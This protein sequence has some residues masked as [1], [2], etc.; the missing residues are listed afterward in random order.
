MKTPYS[1]QPF[2]LL[3]KEEK[4]LIHETSMRILSEIGVKVKNKRA[5]EHLTRAGCNVNKDRV[6]IPESTVRKTLDLTAK[7]VH[8]PAMDE[9]HSFTVES[10]SSTITYGTGGQALY[11]VSRKDGKF[12]RKSADGEDLENILHL[13][14]RLPNVDFVTRPVEPQVD[15]ED[16][17][18]EKMKIF[19][20]N[21]TK[22]INLANL[23]KPEK[24]DDIIEI[25]G[26]KDLLSFIVCLVVSPLS[27]D[28]GAADKLEAIAGHDMAVCI[29][30]CPQGGATAPL[31]ELGE[32]AQVNAEVLTGFVLANAV[33]PG[34]KVFYRGIPITSDLLHD[35]S[36]RWC[37]PDSIRR[38]ALAAEMC[39]FYGIP[40]CGTAAVSDEK[41]PTAQGIAE[42]SLSW[43]FEGATG[44]HYINSAL[45]MLE[46]VM[47]VSP[48]QYVIDDIILGQ[49]KENLADIPPEELPRFAASSVEKALST[50]G[51]SVNDSIREE[52]RRSIDF[53]YEKKDD[54]TRENAEKQFEAIQSACTSRMGSNVF[55]KG[56]RRPLR[57]GV[58]YQGS[59]IEGDIDF[60]RVDRILK[61]PDKG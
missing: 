48:E 10:S 53:I 7:T 52:I 43:I 28:D 19:A 9:G 5:I 41:E 36:P 27:I 22:P 47:T 40:C 31:S 8:F 14:E 4:D 38:V 59:R 12:V 55:M 58:L 30:S 60:T 50:F 23:I 3:T 57:Q 25:I 20:Q 16:M 32:L 46:Q 18:V 44:A 49:I 6:L 13:C 61:S 45:G 37:R 39:R 2:S 24:L 21:T 56:A 1:V 35:G 26:N 11:V 29:S 51:I 15:A 34:A 17:D 33:R 42:K 54:Y